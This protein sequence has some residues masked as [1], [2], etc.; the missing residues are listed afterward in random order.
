[1]CVCVCV[2]VSVCVCVCVCVCER[3]GGRGRAQNMKS[4]D[5]QGGRWRGCRGSRNAPAPAPA[6][7]NVL[8]RSRKCRC[9]GPMV[10]AAALPGAIPAAAR[11]PS[12]IGARFLVTAEPHGGLRHPGLPFHTAPT[13]SAVPPTLPLFC[14]HLCGS[15]S[16]VNGETP[17]DP[18]PHPC[19]VKLGKP[20]LIHKSRFSN[21]PLPIRK[22]LENISPPAVLP[23]V[24]RIC[25]FEVQAVV[26]VDPVD[27]AVA[28]TLQ[29]PPA[30][31]L[32]KRWRALGGQS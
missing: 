1:V 9:A 19:T 7:A 18:E 30:R 23:G 3:E 5:R 26:G 14:N 28:H 8:L 17:L 11:H 16:G 6:A 29:L 4:C 20:K 13:T 21:A 24:P 27:A 10:E 22:R 25:Q 15:L 31:D 32:R 2:C 12:L